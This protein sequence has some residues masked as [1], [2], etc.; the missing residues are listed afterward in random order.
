[1]NWRRSNAELSRLHKRSPWLYMIEWRE[2]LDRC[3]MALDGGAREKALLDPAAARLEAEQLRSSAEW[4]VLIAARLDK[5]AR[6]T[7]R[8]A[9]LRNVEGRTAQEAA[10]YLAKADELDS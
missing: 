4:L 6:K 7:E 10:V 8:V 9:A 3:V 2:R 1:M 5:G